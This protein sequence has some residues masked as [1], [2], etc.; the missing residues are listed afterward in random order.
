MRRTIITDENLSTR[1]A[2]ELKRRGFEAQSIAHLG[3]KQLKDPELI[4]ALNGLDFPWV[5]LTGDDKLPL[6]HSDVVE[7][8]EPT[9][10]VIGPRITSGRGIE[11]HRADVTHRWAHKIAVQDEGTIRRYS[12][13]SHRLW[14]ALKR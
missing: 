13:K 6:V 14:V 10:A 5:L 2:T 4:A 8:Y 3:L 12:S 11:M 9:I 7:L 1:M